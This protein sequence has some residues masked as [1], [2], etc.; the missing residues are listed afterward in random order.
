[1]KFVC[2]KSC[3]DNS[4]VVG[5]RMDSEYDLTPKAAEHLFNLGFLEK[6][7]RPS[8]FASEQLLRTLSKRGGKGPEKQDEKPSESK[9]FENKLAEK[10]TLEGKK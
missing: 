9:P 7:F 4:S 8:D 10:P 1:M 6:Y 2:T 5:Y 3:F